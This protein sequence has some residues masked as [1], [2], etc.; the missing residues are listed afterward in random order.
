MR[1]LGEYKTLVFDC[2]GV[3]LDSNQLKTQAYHNTAVRHGASPAQ[4]QAL[5]DHHVKFG[6]ISRYP[7]YELFLRE[8]MH[9]EV[10]DA[11]V[12]KLLDSF[13]EEI[14]EGLLTCEV[15]PGLERLREATPNAKWLMVSGAD[16]AELRT[17]FAARGLDHLFNGGIFGSPANK[18]TILAREVDNGNLARPAIFFGDSLYDHQAAARVELDF[19]FVNLWTE[20]AG[21]EEYVK[22]NGIEVIERL[23]N[24]I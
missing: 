19:V 22:S 1:D 12:K 6:G 21:W 7:K 20:F 5:V 10:T 24:I 2:D 3:V 15:A 14:R 8:I 18:D 23:E 16:Q 11:A 17:L 4:A 13:A 9:Q